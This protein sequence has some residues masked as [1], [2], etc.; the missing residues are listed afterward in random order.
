MTVGFHVPGA[1]PRFDE[2]V[3]SGG[4][5]GI[6]ENLGMMG[7]INSGQVARSH[8]PTSIAAIGAILMPGCSSGAQNAQGRDDCKRQDSL[9]ATHSRLLC[10]AHGTESKAICAPGKDLF[11]RHSRLV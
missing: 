11:Q 9:I 8:A 6:A 7:R 4:D 5:G 1:I 2:A 10:Y 3:F